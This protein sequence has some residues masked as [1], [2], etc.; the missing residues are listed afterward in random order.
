MAEFR[1]VWW[2][3]NEAQAQE[4][5]QQLSRWATADAIGYGLEP[6]SD[7]TVDLRD[8]RPDAGETPGTIAEVIVVCTDPDEPTPSQLAAFSAA[9]ILHEVAHASPEACEREGRHTFTPAASQAMR[10]F[11]DATAQC[12]VCGTEVKGADLAA[13]GGLEWRDGGWRGRG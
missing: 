8:A 5:M 4:Q 12:L 1:K 13:A 7:V 3:A 9:E 11:R 2:Y 10:T 6:T